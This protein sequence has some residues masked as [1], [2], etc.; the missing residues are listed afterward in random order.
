MS[1]LEGLA[2]PYSPQL[3]DQRML[4]CEPTLIILNYYTD[5]LNRGDE[6]EKRLQVLEILRIMMSSMEEDHVYTLIA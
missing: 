4:P 6:E 3:A 5:N 1:L 2:D